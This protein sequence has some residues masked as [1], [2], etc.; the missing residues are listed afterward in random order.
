MTSHARSYVGMGTVLP[1]GSLG[2]VLVDT[3]IQKEICVGSIPALGAIFSIF[4]PSMT[5]VP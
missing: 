2:G 4:T 5:L 3:L 1:S